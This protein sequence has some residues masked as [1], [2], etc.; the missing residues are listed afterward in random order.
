MLRN[1]GSNWG[2]T[3][4]TIAATYVMTPFIIHT[5]GQE[6][7]GTWTLITAI[8][9]YMSLISLGVPMACVRYLAQDVAEGDREKANVTIGSCAG[10]YL[11]MSAAAVGVGA[12][13][14]LL[15]IAYDIPSAWRA[16]AQLALALIVVQVAAGF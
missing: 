9:G 16:H 3:V 6:G 13:L 10:L 5:L 4:V 1:V 15:V 12:L 11:M 14:T 8:T 7:Y 2:L